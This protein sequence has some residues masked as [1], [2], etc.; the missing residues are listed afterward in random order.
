MSISPR[1]TNKQEWEEEKEEKNEE[2]EKAPVGGRE[3]S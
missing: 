3:I 2:K 1:K